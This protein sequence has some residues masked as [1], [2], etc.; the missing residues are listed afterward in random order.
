M[1]WFQPAVFYAALQAAGPHLTPQTFRDGLFAGRPTQ[2]A[3]TQVSVSWGRH[4]IW[5]KVDYNG[6]DDFTL[7]WWD[8]QAEGPDEIRKP[9]KGL[10]QYVDGGKRY[11]LGQF[12]RAAPKM[13][14][15]A[16]A[17]ALYPDIPAAERPPD[18]PPPSPRR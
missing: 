11:L 4:G 7:L 18:Y 8:P 15:R 2:H 3:I 17:V 14:D 10:Y 1:L 5:P 6:V 13:F 16:G 9:G 12:P